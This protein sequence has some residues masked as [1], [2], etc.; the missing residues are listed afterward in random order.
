M[1]AITF[2]ETAIPTTCPCDGSGLRSCLAS[3]SR[4]PAWHA[5]TLP[6]GTEVMLDM[7]QD[8]TQV[9]IDAV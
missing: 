9:L 5:V 4:D 3:P 8:L 6:C 1:P 7:P 2:C